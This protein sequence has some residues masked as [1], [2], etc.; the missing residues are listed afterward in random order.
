MNSWSTGPPTKVPQGIQVQSLKNSSGRAKDAP[1]LYWAQW[2][3]SHFQN[4]K[5]KRW[6]IWGP[7]A[8]RSFFFVLLLAK[9]YQASTGCQPYSGLQRYNMEQK[10]NWYCV[11][12]IHHL[13]REGDANQTMT[14]LKKFRLRGT[15]GRQSTQHYKVRHWELDISLQSMYPGLNSCKNPEKGLSFFF[16]LA[17]WGLRKSYI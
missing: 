11:H 13:A 3:A 5:F 12:G 14:C 15:W 10:R 1:K 2:Y 7:R 8:W 17:Y 6:S 16:L 9:S 4:L